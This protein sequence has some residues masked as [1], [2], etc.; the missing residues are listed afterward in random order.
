M[1]PSF[2][3][4][5]FAGVLGAAGTEANVVYD[6]GTDIVKAAAIASSADYA[7]IFAGTLSHE[8]G[9][10]A[11][12]SLDDGCDKDSY[13]QCDGNAHNQNAMIEAVAK[14]NEKVIV[15]LSVPGAVVMPW[16]GD[17]AAIVTNFMPGQQAGNA[18]ADVLFGKVNPSG[19]LPLTFP[20]GENET[21]MSLAQWPGLPNP[22]KPTYAYYMEK[23]LVGYRH[24]DA[25]NISF[26]TGFPFG[27]GLSYTTFEY[28]NLK[29]QGDKS[30]SGSYQVTFTIKNSGTVAGAEVAQLYLG[31]PGSAGEPLRQL[32]GFGKTKV[33]AAGEEQQMQLNLR[34]RDTSIWDVVRHEWSVVIG[35]YQVSIG[36]SSRDLRLQASFTVQHIGEKD[37]FV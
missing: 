11:S 30:G 12:L 32:K 19:K 36:S 7:I 6:N 20:N 34:P 22:K 29:V 4:S 23:L 8:G 14:A 9:D 2:V 24:Y 10:R 21:E 15:V 25:H 18:V 31:F 33:L 28:S 1:V 16:S 37:V 5:P 17:V 13:G 3:A 35:K 27:H 26:T